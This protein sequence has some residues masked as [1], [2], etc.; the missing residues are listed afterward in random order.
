MMP[1]REYKRGAV[2][3]LA[4]LALAGYYLL[5]FLPL[6]HR[7]DAIEDRLMQDWKKLTTALDQ[8]NAVALDFRRINNQIQE[9]RQALA[10]LKDARKQA[11]A[12]FD[13]SP[14]LRAKMKPP[15]QLVEFENERGKEMDELSSLA[16]QQQVA[17]E[18]AVLAGFPEYTI[19]VQQ[20]ALL[21]PALSLVDGLLVTA[22]QCK[23]TAIHALESPLVF[24]N[25]PLPDAALRP[26]QIPL[27]FE[28]TGPVAG[29]LRLVQSLPLRGEEL[30]AAGFT[31]APPGKLPL[32]LD[33]LII[34]KQSPDKPDEVRVG[35]RL[36]GFV[37]Q[38]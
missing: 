29:V 1:L 3:P 35:L 24:T 34:K 28:F 17:L 30:R 36:I 9:T 18:P 32:L 27:Q 12:H 26:A 2:V 19:D 15:F 31:N 21:W 10:E 20:P 22:I 33:R 25:A 8:T 7:A 11:S 16:K 37:F 6:V 13:L 5:V 14:G 38:E 23:V 4:G